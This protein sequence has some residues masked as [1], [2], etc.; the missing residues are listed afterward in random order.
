[1]RSV[2][3]EEKDGSWSMATKSRWRETCRERGEPRLPE[4]S[5]KSGSR[6]IVWRE[7]KKR[8]RGGSL[9]GGGGREVGPSSEECTLGG[10]VG[11]AEPLTKK[12]GLAVW[13]RSGNGITG[14]MELWE[15]EDG[16]VLELEALRVRNLGGEGASRSNGLLKNALVFLPIGR[17]SGLVT[18]EGRETMG[19]AL[20][21]GA[22]S[23][24]C[25]GSGD[26]A[27]ESG[28]DSHALGT[29]S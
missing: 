6:S 27:L 3:E 7:G 17:V 2:G 18:G 19:F 29:R 20:G 22:I 26:D 12:L 16:F 4:S 11:V 5:D 13:A 21:E 9:G 14:S 28:G 24:R 15:G 1:M 8:E 10:G 25:G 23:V